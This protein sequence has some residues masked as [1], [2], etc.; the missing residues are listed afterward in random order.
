MNNLN[1][2]DNIIKLR[3]N[4]KITQE[5]LADFIGVTKGSVSKWETGQSLP[6]IL[7]LPE[8]AAFFD[9]T[10]D[11]LLGYKPQLSREQIHKIYR[12]LAVAFAEQPFHQVMLKSEDYVKKYYSCYPFLFQICVLWLNHFMLAEDKMIQ[13][14]VLT[15][16]LDL[17]NHIISNCKNIGICE[18]TVIVKAAADLQLGNAIQAIEATEEILNPRRL[19]SQSDS[20]LIQ[21]YMLADK[22]ENADSFTQMSMFLH[23]NS[24]I[25]AAVWH[26]IIHNDNLYICEITIQR[27]EN[28][29]AA[30]ELQ[31]FS[32]GT[33]TQFH[34][35]AAIVYSMHKKK[36]QAVN[37]LK[38]YADEVDFLLTGDNL[39]QHGDSY[40]YSI[41]KWYD[42][43]DL[44][45]DAP[46]DKRVIY[47]SFVQSFTNPV[48]SALKD[49]KEYQDI[50]HIVAKKGEKL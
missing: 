5:Q 27:I 24:L 19:A 38:K 35:Q 7:T 39:S 22:K 12:D 1:F 43:L 26:L 30:Y 9:V 10:I 48:F 3:H 17:C 36:E 20:V 40:F 33:T 18:D 8:L 11:E 44:G 2:S 21:A 42:Q 34:Y 50:C 45:T 37:M 41:Q 31:K 32:Q 47:D 15:K 13:E 25:A 6:D 46:R 29:I 49:N 28:L 16:L 23:L 14:T 4:K